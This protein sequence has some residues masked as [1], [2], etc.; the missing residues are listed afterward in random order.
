MVTSKLR[1]LDQRVKQLVQVYAAHRPL[2]QR[3]LTV[4]FVLYVLTASYRGL[5]AHQTTK[6]EKEKDAAD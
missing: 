2:V 6:K 1:P 4:G 5:A 3:G